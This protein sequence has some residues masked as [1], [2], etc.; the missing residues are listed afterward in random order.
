MGEGQ[1]GWSSE[2]RLGRKLF[3]SNWFR[4]VRRATCPFTAGQRGSVGTGGRQRRAGQ[5]HQ[6]TSHQQKKRGGI[7]IPLLEH[8]PSSLAM[9]MLLPYS[10]LNLYPSFP[11]NGAQSTL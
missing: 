2:R 6:A 11:P 9:V 4:P 5:A 7:P 8:T 1:N 3:A 10:L